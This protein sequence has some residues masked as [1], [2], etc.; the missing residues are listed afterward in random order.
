MAG[1]VQTVLGSI[2]PSSLGR[3]LMHEHILVDAKVRDWA[4]KLFFTGFM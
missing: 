2:D 1:T 3:V 4:D